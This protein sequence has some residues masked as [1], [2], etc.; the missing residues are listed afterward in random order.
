[1]EK[2]AGWPVGEPSRV[3]E[4]LP[5]FSKASA[6]TSWT[7]RTARPTRTTALLCRMIFALALRTTTV[8]T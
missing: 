3:T 6:S 7:T 1:M 4:T 5:T 2:L 8:T